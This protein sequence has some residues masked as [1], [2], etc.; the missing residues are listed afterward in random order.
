MNLL[1]NNSSKP[2]I[3]IL[4]IAL[5]TLAFCFSCGTVKKVKT[6]AIVN[7]TVSVA[8]ANYNSSKFTTKK[9][10]SDIEVTGEFIVPGLQAGDI[11][12]LVM[13]MLDYINFTNGRKAIFVYDSGQVV[14]ARINLKLPSQDEDYMLVF[15][16]TASAR[17]D[18]QVNAVINL[19]YK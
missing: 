19:K 3:D 14:T 18:K 5:I 6:Q 8:N 17:A 15:D 9:T 4:L 10:W 1:K 2:K 12:V 13:T 7:G 16:N 11:R